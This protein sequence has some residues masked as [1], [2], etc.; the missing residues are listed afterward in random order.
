MRLCSVEG[1][2]REHYAKGFCVRHYRQSPEQKA[3][4]KIRWKTYSQQPNVKAFRKVY[5]Q[6]SDV[7]ARKKEWRRGWS[8]IRAVNASLRKRIAN[9][10]AIPEE[11]RSPV[12]CARLFGW[13]LLLVQE[14]AVE[15][16]LFDR[17]AVEGDCRGT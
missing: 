2:G 7:K 9:A 5:F 14:E 16:E 1:C 8:Q 13:R 15:K 6:R 3:R 4:S 10:E 11:K 12:V 17:L